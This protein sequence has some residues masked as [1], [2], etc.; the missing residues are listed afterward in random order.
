MNRATFVL[1]G[2]VHGARRHA[3][4][5][6]AVAVASAVLV[7]ALAVGDSVRATLSEAAA[8]RT[9]EVDAVL[10]GGDRF[11]RAELADPRRCCSSSASPPP[12]AATSACT[13][14]ASTASTQPSTHWRRARYGAPPAPARSPIHS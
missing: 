13:T 12:R 4:V 3:G 5:A 14:C 10:A 11:F 8:A 7:G 2:L 1:A 6:A 9:G